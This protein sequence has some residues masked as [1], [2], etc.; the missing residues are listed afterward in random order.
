MKPPEFILAEKY[1]AICKTVALA[2]LY[3]PV[4]PVSY[5]IALVGM[6]STYWI[7]KWI[8]LRRSQKPA[9]LKNESTVAVVYT[10]KALSATQP[11][12]AISA[13][14]AT[15]GRHTPPLFTST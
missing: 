6:T 11:I 1:A 7:D 10:M 2:I 3:G 9:R 5:L 14:Y 12:I 8:A 15:A 13:F 4:L